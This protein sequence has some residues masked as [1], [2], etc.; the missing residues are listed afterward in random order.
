MISVSPTISYACRRM[1]LMKLVVFLFLTLAKQN[2]YIH[3]HGFNF[4]FEEVAHV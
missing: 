2:P 3:E 1:I 4:V